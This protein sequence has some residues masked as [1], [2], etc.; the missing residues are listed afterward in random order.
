MKKLY[1]RETTVE[2]CKGDWVSHRRAR[3]IFKLCRKARRANKGIDFS[4]IAPLLYK[5]RWATHEER[6]IN[7][8][9]AWHVPSISPRG[10]LNIGCKVF[11]YSTLVKVARELGFKKF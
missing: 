9:E 10:S 7:D 1:V 5:H 4:G 8:R 6:Q 11:L 3:D 2:T